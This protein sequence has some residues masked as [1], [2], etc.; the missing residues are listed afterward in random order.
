MRQHTGFLV[1][2]RYH[3]YRGELKAAMVHI[4]TDEPLQKVVLT[5]QNCLINDPVGAGDAEI[6]GIDKTFGNNPPNCRFLTWHGFMHRN[7]RLP[8]EKRAPDSKSI[9]WFAQRR[10][11]AKEIALAMLPERRKTPESVDLATENLLSL[12]AWLDHDD[13]DMTRSCL[14]DC[15]TEGGEVETQDP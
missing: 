11:T 14:F 4:W 2:L 1:T 12:A 15:L 13:E 9:K 10:R 6:I 7:P 5:L 3:D 8:G